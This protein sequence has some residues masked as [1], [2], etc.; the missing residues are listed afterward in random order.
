[1]TPKQK[2]CLDFIRSFHDKNGFSPNYAEI[3]RHLGS[4]SK[5]SVF[6]LVSALVTQGHLVRT[7]GSVRNL[8]IVEP[9]SPLALPAELRIR[10]AL[11]CRDRGERPAAVLADVVSQVLDAADVDSG[12]RSELSSTERE[13]VL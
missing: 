4:L 7:E 6:G 12:C 2:R 8:A 5:S 9:D 13:H 3:G 10:L 1:M 11:Y